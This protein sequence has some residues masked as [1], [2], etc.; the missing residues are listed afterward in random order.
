MMSNYN[1]D[2]FKMKKVLREL[3]MVI[4]VENPCIYEIPVRI[5]R[6]ICESKYHDS[7]YYLISFYKGS[8]AHEN[9]DK[10][11]WK[12]VNYSYLPKKY[13]YNN[14]DLVWFD[15]NLKHSYAVSP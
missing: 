14:H 2:E 9:I 12:E 1:D 15:F 4:P 8:Y 3:Q 13:K 6:S 5:Y 7:K 11:V 10:N